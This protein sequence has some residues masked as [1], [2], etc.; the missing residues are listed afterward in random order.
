VEEWHIP[1]KLQISEYSTSVNLGDVLWVQ[2]TALLL[3]MS[4]QWP[5]T[6]LYMIRNV[7]ESLVVLL[8]VPWT[9]VTIYHNRRVMFQSTW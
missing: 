3:H 2:N 5:G 7:Y 1:R 6:S 4:T 8:Q 9:H